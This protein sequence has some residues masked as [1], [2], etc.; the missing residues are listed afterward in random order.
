MPLTCPVCRAA[1]DQGPDCRRCKADLSLL[2]AL[3]AQRGVQLG[4][5]GLALQAGRFEAAERMAARAS[6]IRGGADI[7][8]LLAVAR[9]LKRDFPAAWIAYR[10]ARSMAEG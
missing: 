8:Q 4:V 9:L 3:E 7:H 6:A 1:N 10:R 2:F 5:A